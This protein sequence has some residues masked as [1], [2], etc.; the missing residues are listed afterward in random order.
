MKKLVIAVIV[1]M[2][3]GFS[4]QA[5][6]DRIEEL[7][8]ILK[9][10]PQEDSFRVNRL[11]ELSAETN[12][13]I[14][15]RTLAAQEGLKISKKINYLIGEINAMNSLSAGK[16][17]NGQLEEAGVIL[18]E[19][20]ALAEQLEDKSK[21]V[22]ILSGRAAHKVNL[23]QNDSAIY[24]LKIAEKLTEN[25]SNKMLLPKVQS[26][27]GSY[28]MVLYSNFPM[29]MEWL[30]KSIKTAESVGCS[31]CMVES[32][33]EMASIY[34]MIGDQKSALLYL[35][36]ALDM[37]NKLG[38]RTTSTMWVSIGER[39]RLV[40]DYAKALDAYN[41]G[42]RLD[43]SPYM[44]EIIE[45]NMADVYLRM[46]NL[47]LAF[48]YAF[49]SLKTATQLKDDVGVTWIKGI[50]ARAY[51]KKNM[52][53]S[54]IYY[55]SDGLKIAERYQSLEYMRDNSEALS[56]AYLMKKD[57]KNAYEYNT[58]FI[59]YRDSMVNHNVTNQTNLL[60]YNF[61]KEKTEA[62]ID[63]LE[64]QKKNQKN[65][66]IA[67]LVT[68]GLILISS[69]LLYRSNRQK[70]RANRLLKQQ[71]EVIDAKAKELTE[72][73][74]NLQQSYNNVELLGDIGRKITSSLTIE[75]II[76][77]V[78]TH[79]NQLMDASIFGVG[80]YNESKQ[81]IDFPST[82][83]KGTPLPPYSNS[84]SDQ[85]RFASICFNESRDI[86]MGDIE[87][88]YMSYVKEISTP[89]LGEKP[90]SLIFLPLQIKN[91]KAGVITVQSL[92]KN[93]YTDYHVFMLRNIGI[94]TAI[95]LENAESFEKLN[96][97]VKSLKATQAQ[98]VQ[99]EK[100]ASLGEL[101][102]GIAHEIQNPLNFVNN[103]SDIN[104]ELV[105]ELLEEVNQGNYEEVKLIAKNIEDN[106]SK[107]N[108]HGKRADAIVKGMLQHS[109]V[110]TG[111]KEATDINAIADEYLRLSYH[112]IRAKDK[113]FNSGMHTDFDPTIGKIQL[114]PQDIGRVLLN[115]IN[116]AFYAVTEKK[117]SQP[118]GSEYSPMVTVATKKQDDHV[119]ISVTDNGNGI[120][121]KVAEK[122]FQPFFTT[123]PSGEG[124]GLG[125]SMSYDIVKAH[126]GILT[127]DTTPGEGSVF[128]IQLPIHHS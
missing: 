18:N 62:H 118:A 68:L 41:E 93:A 21:L 45:S 114:V 32:W 122:I 15:E 74:S 46:N 55:A 69:L 79:V 67:A 66:L 96:Q 105:N 33:S 110:N 128:T 100:M 123:K 49:N 75:N 38:I 72:Q 23:G 34:S 88:E 124:T 84:L 9:Q 2:L 97:T 73:K 99:S 47:P 48:H 77:T 50:L 5:Q 121:Q 14:P 86:V 19:A 30:L 28:Y 117:K 71:K 40:G 98:L 22:E 10:H 112:G 27:I 8:Q 81:T 92:K 80:I 4:S 1:L 119:Q 94:Y 78:Y 95:A 90:E 13:S 44:I 120:P 11:H 29:G 53:D 43:K 26:S 12:L 82:Y 56:K 58:K 60:H 111:Q 6:D 115:L 85:N 51:L 125:L 35:Q 76:G 52:P 109:R 25:A 83:E 24:L 57:Y 54:A 36:K 91:K 20:Y 113:S 101:T 59:L 103:F 63:N 17:A 16:V 108:M 7:R 102:A 126:E 3:T 64:Q 89:R 37:N 70:L 127:V 65:I 107:I 87:N 106:E 104:Q 116:N 39:Y 31:K 42:L 61:N